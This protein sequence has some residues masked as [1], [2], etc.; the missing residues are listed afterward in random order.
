MS[1]LFVILII[2]IWVASCNIGCSTSNKVKSVTN[3]K[4]DS[5]V[6][7]RSDSTAKKSKTKT[8]VN[9]T[10]SAVAKK[11]DIT[12]ERETITLYDTVRKVISVTVKEK[13]RDKSREMAT[14]TKVDSVVQF[15]HDTV[16]VTKTG[17]AEVHKEV[18]Q[19]DKQVKS[20]SYWGWLWLLLLIPAY[21]V[22]RNW[23]KIKGIFSGF[24]I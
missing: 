18:T 10:Q 20:K 17:T 7:T 8:Q 13:G 11:K 15:I 4:I 14:V 16:V 1:R 6:V 19:K 22:Y 12:Y 5:A 3:S 21:L 23:N 2:I 24:S 9:K